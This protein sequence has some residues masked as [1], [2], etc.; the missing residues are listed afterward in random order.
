LLPKPESPTAGGEEVVIPFPVP[1]DQ[2]KL[3]T[4]YAGSGI[5]TSLSM[6]RERGHYATY[7]R[8]LPAEHHAALLSVVAGEWIPIELAL[9]HYRACDRMGLPSQEI[10]EM[11]E[12]SSSRLYSPAFVLAAKLMSRVGVTPWSVF[13][14]LPES[15]ARTL[16]GGS[17]VSVVKLGP[18]E[19]RFELEGYPLAEIP[20]VRAGFI[21]VVRH[22]LGLFCRRVIVREVP[23]ERRPNSAAYH[24]SWI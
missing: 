17:A 19:A 22:P 11:G 16:R 7:L 14:K 23:G 24:A 20:Y 15:W 8:E 6:L 18:K 12:V 21:G 10:I 13:R 3:A 2:V 9:V 1:R 5:S 4:E